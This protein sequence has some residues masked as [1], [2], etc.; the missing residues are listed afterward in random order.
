MAISQRQIVRRMVSRTNRYRRRAPL[1]PEKATSTTSDKAWQ[2]FFIRMASG[3]IC[4]L[5][6]HKRAN[7]Q[8]P[9]EHQR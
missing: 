6:T 1:V 3:T 9:E 4:R 7:A 8:I 5:R 2:H